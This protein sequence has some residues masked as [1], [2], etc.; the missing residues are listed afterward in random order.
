MSLGGATSVSGTFMTKLRSYN[1][2]KEFGIV[3]SYFNYIF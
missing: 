3:G 2:Y 1:K